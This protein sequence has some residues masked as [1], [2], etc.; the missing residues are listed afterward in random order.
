MASIQF[1]GLASGLDTAGI[2]DAMLKAD[3]TRI[4]V[5]Q[6]RQSTITSQISSIGTLK[7]KLSTLDAKMQALRF[8]SQEV[9][10]LDARRQDAGPALQQPGSD[11]QGDHEHPVDLGERPDRVS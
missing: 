8:S 7:S 11:L 5:L 4:Q 3:Q 1:S 10:A 6:R 9:E 2:I